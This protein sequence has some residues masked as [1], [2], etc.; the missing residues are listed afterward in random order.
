MISGEFTE[1]FMVS[2]GSWNEMA[3]MLGQLEFSKLQALSRQ[4]YSTYV[5]RAHIKF[6]YGICIEEKIFLARVAEQSER[7]R[8]MLNFLLEVL[9]QKYMDEKAKKKRFDIDKDLQ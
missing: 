6:D 1:R 8:D 7:F 3:N 5:P 2:F 4:A 9:E